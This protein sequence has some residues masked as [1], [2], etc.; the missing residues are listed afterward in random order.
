M[1]G[2]DFFFLVIRCVFHSF[3]QCGF[4][5]HEVRDAGIG[6]VQVSPCGVNLSFAYMLCDIDGVFACGYFPVVSFA[7]V[8]SGD[9]LGGEGVVSSDSRVG[10][11]DEEV[12]D[13]GEGERLVIFHSFRVSSFVCGG[14]SGS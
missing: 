10:I 5:C 2:G 13:G 9:G 8:S 7:I 14:F 1:F 6:C 4:A 11:P 3:P 12:D